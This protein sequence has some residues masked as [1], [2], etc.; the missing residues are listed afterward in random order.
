MQGQEIHTLYYTFSYLLTVPLPENNLL[1][2][3][4]CLDKQ[5]AFTQVFFL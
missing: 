2:I 1:S 4:L 5:D 3:P